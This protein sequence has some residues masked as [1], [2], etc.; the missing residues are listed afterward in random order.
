MGCGKSAVANVVGTNIGLPIIESDKIIS[1][2][3][4]QTITE[5]FNTSGQEHFRSQELAVVNTLEKNTSYIISTGGGAVETP[6][7][8]KLLKQNGIVI[9]LDRP[10]G[11]IISEI[12]SDTKRPLVASL[13]SD[14]LHAIYSRR[15]LQYKSAA[16]YRI[17]TGTLSVALAADKVN[18]IRRECES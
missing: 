4:G 13:S 6:E 3:I 15:C 12:G 11:Q 2:L 5:I 7:L 18:E 16:D 1:E 17:D 8:I 10:W 14:E 9:W